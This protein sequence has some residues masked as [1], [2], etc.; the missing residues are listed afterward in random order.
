MTEEFSP[1]VLSVVVPVLNEA[2]LIERTLRILVAQDTID[3]VI[4]VDN[5]SDDGT[6]DIVRGFAA[7]H[8]KVELLHE[9]ARGTAFARNAGFD[10]ARG[11]LVARTDADTFVEDDWGATIREYFSGHPETAAVTGL[12]TY[13]DSPVGYLLRFGQWVLL[14][15]G[16]IGGRVGNMYGPNMAIR[17]EAWQQV[18]DRTQVRADIA[19]D[20]DL[21]VCLSLCGLRID[22]VAEMRARTS[23]RRRRTSPR[24]YWRFHLAGVRTLG[25]HGFRIRPV[26]WVIIAGAWSAHTLQ[27]PIYRFWDFD[28]RRFSSRPGAARISSVGD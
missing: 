26:H 23:S 21:A 11:E 8:P 6:P 5:A 7:A 14:R 12:C 18:R 13:H 10:R 25:Y 15:C 4:V 20:L 22:Q 17:R 24:R 2:A 28:R 1:A 27:W 16:R 9:S 19:E 3:E